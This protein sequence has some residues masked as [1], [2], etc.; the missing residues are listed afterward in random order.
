MQNAFC[1]SPFC[2]SRATI[3][4]LKHR[5]ATSMPTGLGIYSVCSLRSIN[6][7]SLAFREQA[8]TETAND[9]NKVL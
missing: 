5:E 2:C 1:F 8:V 7:F 6:V 9:K 3:C 4:Q